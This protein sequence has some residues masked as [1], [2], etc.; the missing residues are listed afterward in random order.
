[1]TISGMT[2]ALALL[3]VALTL[4]N[5]GRDAPET[6]GATTET[7]EAAAD[8]LE[9][10]D[11]LEA[12][13]DELAADI[14]D[15]RSDRKALA[16]RVGKISGKLRAALADLK[17]SLRDIEDDVDGATAT[18]GDALARIGGV[19]RDLEVMENRFDYHL[20]EGH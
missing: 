6:D 4:V 11:E 16:A 14:A 7:I 12:Q 15:L 18:A 9:A 3:F 19:A 13:T 5:C 17:T 20:R 10:V 8:A 2:R 1:M